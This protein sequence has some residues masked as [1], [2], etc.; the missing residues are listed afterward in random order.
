MCFKEKRGSHTA[1]NKA[2]GSRS[3]KDTEYSPWTFW[4]SRAKWRS[5]VFQEG[6]EGKLLLA[7]DLK[8][9]ELEILKIKE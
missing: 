7:K 6:A 9:R 5:W 4:G 3:D 2:E 8:H 1:G